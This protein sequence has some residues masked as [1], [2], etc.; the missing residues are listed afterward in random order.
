MSNSLRK[1]AA[2][3]FSATLLTQGGLLA[4]SKKGA[5]ATSDKPEP[6]AAKKADAKAGAPKKAAPSEKRDKLLKWTTLESAF[7]QTQRKERRLLTFI[8]QQKRKLNGIKDDKQKQK[9][10]QGIDKATK[11]LQALSAAMNVLFAAQPIARNYVY[12]PVNSNVYLQV[13]SL[14]RVFARAIRVRDRLAQFIGEQQALKEAEKDT[15]KKEDIDKKI[16]NATRQYRIVAA[17][18]QVVFGVV[19]QRSYQYDPKSSTLY[20]KVS[21][22]EIA[23]LREQVKTLQD[24]RAATKA[25]KGAAAKGKDKKK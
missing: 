15:K 2:I 10:Q 23:K 13:G 19:P 3:V 6:V 5:K 16:Q 9:V 20:L 4:A 21:D 12:N 18:L 14:Q 24:K 1:S 11:Q 8:V 7:V 17:A 25:D 22:S